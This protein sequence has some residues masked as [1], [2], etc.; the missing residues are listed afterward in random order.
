ME[1]NPFKLE[2]RLWT[3]QP[4]YDVSPPRELD[5]SS[6]GFLQGT[7]NFDQEATRGSLEKGTTSFLGAIME[8][9]GKVVG[10]AVELSLIHI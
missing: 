9:L 8:T 4:V 2:E 1:T 3:P 5:Y 7:D 6:F 10:G